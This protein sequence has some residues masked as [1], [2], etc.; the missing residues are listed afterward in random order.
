MFGDFE[1]MQEEMQQKLAAI[2]VEAQSGD[3]AV[4]V[5][6]TAA[7]VVENITLDKA[8]LDVNDTEQLEDLLLVAVNNA[9]QKAQV[10]SAAESQK[11]MNQMLPGGLGSL[12]G[13]FGK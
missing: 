7:L 1:K 6:M 12:G 5:T 8:K 9:I 11:M 4:F 13:L 10:K 2:T 3:G